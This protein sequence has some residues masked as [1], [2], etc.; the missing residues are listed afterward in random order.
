VYAVVTPNLS[1]RLVFMML[2]LLLA[3]ALWQKARDQLPYLLDP[4]ASPPPRVSTS[5]GLIAAMVFFVLQAIIA[6]IV[7]GRGQRVHG[8]S[9]LVAFTLAGGLT[10]LLMRWVYARAKTRDVPRILGGDTAASGA[11][12]ALLAG[13]AAGA[14][15]FGYLY[16]IHATG[17]LQQSERLLNPYAQLGWWA[18]PL[19]LLAAPIFEEFIFRGL[20]FGGLRR[21]FGVWPA[22]LASAG[23]FA[24]VH[25][26]ISVAPVF[27]LGVATAMMYERTRGLLAP[28]IC[29]A[30]YNACA[31]G[32]VWWL[33]QE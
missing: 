11:V 6:A 19:A 18:L 23:L 29:H 15:A 17:V 9:V 28:M 8:A 31:L 12:V 24:V 13:I 33:F 14:V 22:A 2:T 3:F 26:A 1:Q 30:A 7:V 21:S 27:V 32:A 20:I 5:D 4:D 10:Y 16:F 25:P